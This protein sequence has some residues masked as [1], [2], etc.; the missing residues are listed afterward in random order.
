MNPIRAAAIAAL[1]IL[2]ASRGLA[3]QQ[4][5]VVREGFDDGL[6][7]WEQ[8]RLD[9]RQ[10]AYNTFDSGGDRVLVASSSNAA[11]GLVRP[12][13]TPAP[14]RATLQWRWRVTR[15]LTEND[16]ERERRGDDY[17]ARVF[18]MF[19]EHPFKRGTRALSYVWA[20]QEPV[21][22]R[23]RNPVVGDVATIVLRSGDGGAGRWQTEQRNLVV[24]FR[25]AFG[26]D[27]P[28]I[29][30]IAV[31]VDT[32]DTDTELIS[33]FDDFLLQVDPDG[34]GR[35]PPSDAP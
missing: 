34:S 25:E 1:A 5:I 3:A 24:D 16:R 13:E 11:A 28:G 9:R 21:G 26:E 4:T 32:D 19:G 31:L 6:G 27:P 30:A 2:V 7:S 10:T 14:A 12:V 23:Y 20:G 22:A 18:V 29:T 8:V 35:R 33:W 15:S 17:A